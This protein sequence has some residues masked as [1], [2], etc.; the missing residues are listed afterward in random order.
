[1][2]EMPLTTSDAHLR[3]ILDVP[4]HWLLHFAELSPVSIYS[5]RK[6]LVEAERL[7]SMGHVMQRIVASSGDILIYPEQIIRMS[8]AGG[9]PRE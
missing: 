7:A 1:M 9:V 3:L 8:G 5:L 6:A 2:A 4:K